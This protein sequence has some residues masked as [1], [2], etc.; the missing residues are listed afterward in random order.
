MTT[1]HCYHDNSNL[2]P[3][4]THTVTMTTTHCYHDKHTLLPWQPHTVTMTNTHCYHDKHT[5]L[6]WQPH[7]VTMTETH[8]Y[9]DNN[10]LL[11]WQPHTVTMATTHFYHNN[12]Y[13]R[14]RKERKPRSGC[15]LSP[16]IRGYSRC[17]T[18]MRGVATRRHFSMFTIMSGLS[19]ASSQVIFL[20]FTGCILVKL[21]YKLSGFWISIIE[22]GV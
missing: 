3:W 21:S 6:P 16:W 20:R 2:L 4:Q 1:T 13:Y 5:L 22:S 7:T 10:T 9:H 14:K 17:S 15:S 18:Q 8:C 12:T 19:S 11:P